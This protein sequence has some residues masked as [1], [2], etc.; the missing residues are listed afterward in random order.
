M[1]T[2]TIN[3]TKQFD[4]FIQRNVSTGQYQNASEVVC[5]AL[6]VLQ[7]RQLNEQ[8]KLR[9]LRK[10]VDTGIADLERGD[11][12]EFYIDQAAAWLA[13]A[14]KRPPLDDNGD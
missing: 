1:P 13:I 14:G 9:K 6:R 12:I 8:V 7:S 2:R 4:D 11:Y 10:V 5:D 3:L